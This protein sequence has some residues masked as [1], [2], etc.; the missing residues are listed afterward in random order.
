MAA[1]NL[2]KRVSRLVDRDGRRARPKFGRM[3]P[4]IAM[5]LLVL[6]LV[7][8]SP[9][10]PAAAEPT[11][12]MSAYTS[13]GPTGVVSPSWRRCIGINASGQA[14]SILANQWDCLGAL[15]Q[16]WSLQEV[17]SGTFRIIN[18]NSGRCLDVI[19][20]TGAISSGIHVQQF[21]CLSVSQTN[22]LWRFELVQ[23]LSGTIGWYRIRA[24]HS[25]LCL[26]VDAGYSGNTNPPVDGIGMNQW[27]CLPG[28]TGPNGTNGAQV[29]RLSK[30]STTIGGCALKSHVQQLVAQPGQGVG[31]FDGMYS[32]VRMTPYAFPQ[33]APNGSFVAEPGAHIGLGSTGSAGAVETGFYVRQLGDGA[34]SN[35]VFSEFFL[36]GNRI[37]ADSNILS[38]GIAGTLCGRWPSNDQTAD[39]KV[40]LVSGY[41]VTWTG[42]YGN[43]QGY[44]SGGWTIGRPAIEFEL[45]NLDGLR[46]GDMFA[47][48]TLISYRRALNGTWFSPSGVQPL[49]CVTDM[50]GQYIAADT[51][52]MLESEGRPSSC[53]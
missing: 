38:L 46:I 31:V 44:S 26:S 4:L 41:W 48:H 40:S 37:N 8:L 14:N 22:Q 53:I 3:R 42:C 51:W 39:F 6:S 10:N 18:Q 11:G 24:V 25:N 45:Y 29:W 2:R 49:A 21:L 15:S 47:Q 27:E 34:Q 36:G 5:P 7:L 50:F 9:A 12:D 17:Y 52:R 28:T 32:R 35:D 43:M 13:Q 23:N 30:A 19:G 1:E 20:G 33:C 16:L